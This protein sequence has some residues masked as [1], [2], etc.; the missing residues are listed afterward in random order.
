MKKRRNENSQIRKEEFESIVDDCGEHTYGI[1]KAS[2]E[3]MKRRR[4]IISVT[5][6]KLVLFVS[7][8]PHKYICIYV[9][10]FIFIFIHR[11]WSNS[12][13]PGSTI[14]SSSNSASPNPFARIALT[15][16]AASTK[17]FA[18]TTLISLPEASASK[19]SVP[20]NNKSSFSTEVST[21]DE[22]SKKKL[23]L[24]K[25][26]DQMIENCD[27]KTNPEALVSVVKEGMEK[28]YK[29]GWAKAEIELDEEDE[30]EE[31][32]EET[33]EKD[34][35]TIEVANQS[36][37]IPKTTS[38]NTSNVS[39]SSSSETKEDEKEIFEVRAKGFKNSIPATGWKP[40][41]IGMLQILLNKSSKKHRI[42]LKQETTSKIVINF[43][44]VKGMKYHLEKEKN[45]ISILAMMD[46][47]IG[48]EYFMFKVN[49]V[50]IDA[51]S[52][53]LDD[54]LS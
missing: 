9:Y 49:K 25:E 39:S 37:A 3:E 6:H 33:L 50:N 52:K 11:K 22:N 20:S 54:I 26:F 15:S 41:G 53:S 10:N 8:L 23:A 30:D 18:R 42:I 34:N 35:K 44:F 12:P 36:P 13:L 2:D 1:A 38:T 17:P 51:F 31:E 46:E 47:K 14:S 16:N 27:Y 48:F 43:Q 21:L 7:F 4:P 24:L 5:G 40:F 32:E 19:A 45:F 29:A 28:M